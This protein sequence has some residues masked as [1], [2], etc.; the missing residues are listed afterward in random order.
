MWLL[1]FQSEQPLPCS[2]ALHHHGLPLQGGYGDGAA[3][4][5]AFATDT[6]VYVAVV[7][8]GTGPNGNQ[9]QFTRVMSMSRLAGK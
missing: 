9:V 3:Q 2:C 6:D 8:G 7:A 5:I 4:I 1:T